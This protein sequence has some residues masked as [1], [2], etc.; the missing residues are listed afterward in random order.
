[1]YFS[2]QVCSEQLD[3]KKTGIGYKIEKEKW[4]TPGA[5]VL[6]GVC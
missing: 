2:K 5:K 4:T 1:M 6:N 3:K